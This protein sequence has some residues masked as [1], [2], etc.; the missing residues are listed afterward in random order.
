MRESFWKGAERVLSTFSKKNFILTEK[1]KDV[2]LQLDAIFPR[3]C[4]DLGFGE[5]DGGVWK[6]SQRA[7]LHGQRAANG[8]VHR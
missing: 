4:R 2:F 1:C 8:I 7:D 5:H 3:V 6:R